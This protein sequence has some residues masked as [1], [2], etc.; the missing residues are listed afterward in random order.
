MFRRGLGTRGDL[1]FR[2]AR[3]GRE[4]DPSQMRDM[5]ENMSIVCISI[6]IGKVALYGA[7]LWNLA[8]YYML[9]Y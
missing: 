4:L 9:I 7:L 1:K 3:R 6:Y 8:N 2:F 5:Q